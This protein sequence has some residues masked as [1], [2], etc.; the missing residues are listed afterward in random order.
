MQVGVYLHYVD[1][2]S[3]KELQE[4]I[5]CIL[6]ADPF[7]DNN[8]VN[9]HYIEFNG[10][11]NKVK[12]NSDLSMVRLFHMGAH[13]CNNAEKGVKRDNSMG[14]EGS[15]TCA[16]STIRIGDEIHISCGDEIQ[17]RS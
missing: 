13:F 5:I 8:K 17:K 16:N 10:G 11:M 4:N 7:K 2:K 6:V 15:T 3:W 9:Q 1:S 12:F 14:F